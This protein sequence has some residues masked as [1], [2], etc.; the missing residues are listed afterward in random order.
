MRKLSYI[1]NIGQGMHEGAREELR[2]KVR[3]LEFLHHKLS[4]ALPLCSSSA[5]VILAAKGGRRVTPAGGLF[6]SLVQ[7]I[8]STPIV[9]QQ[10]PDVFLTASRMG[11]ARP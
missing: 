9:R 8:C 7:N 6:T 5:R 2:V 10:K 3:P 4:H 11:L 1:E